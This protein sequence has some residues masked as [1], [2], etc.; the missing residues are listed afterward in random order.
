MKRMWIDI[1]NEPHV[2]LWKRFLSRYPHEA[3]ITVRRK[4]LLVDLVKK[5]MP[6]SKPVIVGRWESNEAEKIRAFAE[7][8]KELALLLDKYDVDLAL[9]KGSA[10]QARV[11]FGLSIPF[12][13]LN[14]NDLPPHIITRLT[15][16]LSKVAVVPECFSGPVYGPTI[17]FPG[18]FEISHVLDYL[19]NPT[20]E[21]YKKL[22]LDEGEYIIV[23][24]PPVGSHYLKEAGSFDLLISKL[25]EETRLKEVRFLRE[26][27][28][29]L[30]SGKIVR[31]V[32]DGLD[33]MS[34]SA[35]VISGGGTM[36]REAALLGIPSMSLF[37]KE[38]P[39]V[40]KVLINAG[41]LAKPK[42]RE[43]VREFKALLK[44]RDRLKDLS[45]KFLEDYGDPIDTIEEAIKLAMS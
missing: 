36:A 7:R 2:R 43:L 24:P 11:A 4:G 16:P 12:V 45:R 21:E 31:S 1:V 32:V 37:P 42:A 9:S 14:D 8:V 44:A 15:F 35:G 6:E 23:R 27:G 5:I 30:P 28:I 13:A 26:G 3:L 29:R 18:V 20:K 38:D 33:L 34:T 17:R 22:G 40:S 19:E 39:C 41:L 25:L 10:E